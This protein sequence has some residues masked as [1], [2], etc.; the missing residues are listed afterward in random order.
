MDD[1]DLED[2]W[3]ALLSRQVER[4]LAKYNSLSPQDKV[5]VVAHLMRMS[6]EPGWHP[7]QRDS[8]KAALTAIQEKTE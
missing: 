3:D 5:G 8:A 4:I 2:I 7:E 1:Q 6:Q